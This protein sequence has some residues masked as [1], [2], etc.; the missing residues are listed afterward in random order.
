MLILRKKNATLSNYDFS[1]KRER[2]F[3]ESVRS[4]PQSSYIYGNYQTWTHEDYLKNHA[5]MLGLLK[6]FFDISDSD[7][8]DESEDNKTEPSDSNILIGKF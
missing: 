3:E 8:A 6:E 1:K 2:Y 7:V 5:E 4:L